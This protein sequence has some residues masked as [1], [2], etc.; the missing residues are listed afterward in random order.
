MGALARL[1]PVSQIGFQ[2]ASNVYPVALA[3]VCE[4]LRAYM[5]RQRASAPE[6]A[7]VKQEPS[8]RERL[9]RLME[10]GLA[11][12]QLQVLYMRG[13]SIVLTPVDRARLETA[14]EELRHRRSLLPTPV[15]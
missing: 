2:R 3:H 14:E 4:V 10:A 8:T 6:T 13:G 9:K 1:I 15:S 5:A 11:P 7:V 12:P